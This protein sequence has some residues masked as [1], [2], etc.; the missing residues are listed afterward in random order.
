MIAWS[1]AIQIQSLLAKVKIEILFFFLHGL[2]FL[3]LKL[4]E[5]LTSNSSSGLTKS[6]IKFSENIN[7]SLTVS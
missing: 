7:N 1:Y 2:M 6:E 5:L 4:T 3:Y